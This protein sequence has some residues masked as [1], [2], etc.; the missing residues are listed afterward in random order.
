MKTF[1]KVL[2]YLSIAAISF[3]S[4]DFGST[5]APVAERNGAFDLESVQFTEDIP[6]LFSKRLMIE[7]G[8][9][10]D[11]VRDGKLTDS[12]LRY[13]ISNTITDAMDL[14]VP[15]Q[16]FGYLYKSPETDSIARFQQM[17]F[18]SLA[19]LT[20]KNK[21]PIAY[22]AES[23][24]QNANLR[25][26]LIEAFTKK[27][28]APKYAFRISAEFNQCSYEWE[29]KDRTIQIETSNGMSVTFN[30]GD[31]VA[32]N[33]KYYNLR[34]LIIENSAKPALYAAHIYEFPDKILYN[35]KMHSYKDFQFEKKQKFRDDFLL[36]STYEDYIKNEYGE[37]SIDK[38]EEEE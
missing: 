3:P 23:E 28:G 24:L 10:Y 15:Q 25:K 9:R 8:I 17:Y 27:Y 37:Y 13:K 11:S 21:K 6:Q 5:K 2:G 18:H 14:Q 29:L 12:M 32:R 19:A 36:N 4:C 7:D 1:T 22:Y 33:N 26:S 31:T 30:S 38:A 34:L 16:D 35:G 20:D